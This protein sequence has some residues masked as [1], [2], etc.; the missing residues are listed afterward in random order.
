MAALKR[1]GFSA[2]KKG[3]GSH[4]SFSRQVDGRK[5]TTVVVLGKSRIPG[6]TLQNILKLGGITVEEFGDPS[7]GHRNRGRASSL[8]MP[9]CR[10]AGLFRHPG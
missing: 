10:A 4:Q 1:L 8:V 7:E 2:G 9:N 3:G 5:M 6:G